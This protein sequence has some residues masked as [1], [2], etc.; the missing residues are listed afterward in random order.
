VA[1]NG[2]TFPKDAPWR[3]KAIVS[4]ESG[5]RIPFLK[6]SNRDLSGKLLNVDPMFPVLARNEN[7]VE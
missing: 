2:I 1:G 3:V 6:Q 4:Q 5:R 7:I